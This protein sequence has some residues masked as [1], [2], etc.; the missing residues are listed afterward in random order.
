MAKS[1]VFPPDDSGTAERFATI[2]LT[3]AWL[4]MRLID[5]ASEALDPEND[6][7]RLYLERATEVLMIDDAACNGRV[8]E[9]QLALW[10][11]RR[12][13]AL[14]TRRLADRLSMEDLAAASRLSRTHFARAFK[15]SFDQTPH[16]YLMSRRIAAAQMAMMTVFSQE[17][18]SPRRCCG[19]HEGAPGLTVCSGFD[20]GQSGPMRQPGRRSGREPR[21][22][23]QIQVGSLRARLRPPGA[24]WGTPHDRWSGRRCFAAAPPGATAKQSQ[25]SSC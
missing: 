23:R 18:H 8:P 13:Q 21:R 14:I 7:A 20:A 9:P 1:F 10:Q 11:R 15:A 3:T 19:L 2:S 5:S 4:A 16:A 22:R 12:V 25:S 17:Q 6:E 24:D